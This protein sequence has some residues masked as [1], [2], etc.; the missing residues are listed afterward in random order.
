MN[1]KRRMVRVFLLMTFRS[2]EIGVIDLVYKVMNKSILTNV[3]GYTRYAWY[4][5]PLIA[6]YRAL[7]RPY[8]HT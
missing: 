5:V 4:Q 1:M 7:A 8:A 3:I 6:E 2:D